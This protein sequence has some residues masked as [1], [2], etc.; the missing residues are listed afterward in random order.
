MSKETIYDNLIPGLNKDIIHLISASNN[1][2][3]WMLDLR[4][5]AFELYKNTPMPSW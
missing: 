2:P 4:L 5:K 1:D 3:E